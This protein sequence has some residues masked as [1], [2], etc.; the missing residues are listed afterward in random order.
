MPWNMFWVVKLIMKCGLL[1]KIGTYPNVNHLKAELHTIQKVSDNVDKYL[2]RIKTIKDKLIVAGEKISDNDLIITALTGFPVD[3]NMIRTV[4]I[5]RETPI[6][7]KEFRARLLGVEK[8][9]ETR[10]Q[11]PVHSKAAMYVNGSVPPLQMGLLP[12]LHFYRT[13]SASFLPNFGYGLIPPD[14]SNSSSTS[15]SSQGYQQSPSATVNGFSGNDNNFGNQGN[16]SFGN[17][18]SIF[19][20]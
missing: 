4:I 18:L 9:L 10:M 15:T 2:L 20:Q 17:R 14:S 7:L 1:Y 3:F 8:S 12:Q 5:V 19:W 13:S 16:I 11:S 6:S